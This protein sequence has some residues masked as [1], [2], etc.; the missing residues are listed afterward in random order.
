MKLCNGN[1]FTVAG[2]LFLIKKSLTIRF[3]KDR[4]IHPDFLRRAPCAV[5]H[6][7]A[8]RGH[9]LRGIG[10]GVNAGV[11]GQKIPGVDTVVRTLSVWVDLRHAFFQSGIQLVFV[12]LSRNGGLEQ[13]IF[14]AVGPDILPFP[15]EE[16]RGLPLHADIL[17]QNVAEMGGQMQ[18]SQ[19]VVAVKPAPFALG[20]RLQHIRCAPIAVRCIAGE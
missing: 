8:A 11:L 20:R 9:G 6:R 16:K 5:R 13:D 18:V 1:P 4:K 10:A 14:L 7:G 12:Q 17:A 19:A 3:W 2:L 15:V